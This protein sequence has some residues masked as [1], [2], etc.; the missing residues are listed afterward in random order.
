MTTDAVT[1]QQFEHFWKESF[2]VRL[3][4]VFCHDNGADLDTIKDGEWTAVQAAEFTEDEMVNHSKLFFDL[5]VKIKAGAVVDIK[6]HSLWHL[7]HQTS[8]ELCEQN[9]FNEKAIESL[10][11]VAAR[12][13]RPE[14]VKL[15]KAKIEEIEGEGKKI[16]ILDDFKIPSKIPKDAEIEREWNKIV[17]EIIDPANKKFA[18]NLKPIP[19]NVCQSLLTAIVL[20]KLDIREVRIV[21]ETTIDIVDKTVDH[22]EP[23]L[24]PGG[25]E[26]RNAAVSGYFKHMI[27]T[28][29]GSIITRARNS[30]DKASL[31]DFKR[32]LKNL[33][34][35]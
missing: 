33:G 26:S 31:E 12:A 32:S 11:I 9:M 4:E 21:F 8:M 24:N 29:L 28:T 10:D 27:S 13:D 16:N 5:A 25:A 14:E 15:A 19:K 34:E 22:F 23:Y 35:L 30:A 18:P 6:D 17:D 2:I 20:G 1:R 7:T 3:A